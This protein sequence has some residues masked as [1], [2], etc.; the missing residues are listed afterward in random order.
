LQQE[1][2]EGAEGPGSEASPLDKEGMDVDTLDKAEMDI[3]MDEWCS[4]EEARVQ[5]GS[6]EDW[7]ELDGGSF[8][9]YPTRNADPTRISG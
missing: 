7:D 5:S 9:A 3:N 2:Y 1:A 4:A 6:D 8:F